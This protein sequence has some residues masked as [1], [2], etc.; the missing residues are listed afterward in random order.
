M[1]CERGVLRRSE[2]VVGWYNSVS[3]RLP[4]CSAASST[5]CSESAPSTTECGSTVVV[6]RCVV[7]VPLVYVNVVN[8]HGNWLP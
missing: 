6:G 7:S 2:L 5:F 1:K 8:L 4:C 3:R